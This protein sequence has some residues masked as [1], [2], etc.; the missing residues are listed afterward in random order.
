MIKKI[1]FDLDGT[2]WETKK[3]Y[4]YAYEKL[5]E[6]YQI[7]DPI[8][9]EEVLKYMGVKLD[10]LIESLF[11]FIEDKEE[12]AR[13]AVG[14][15][16]EY[17]YNN[18]KT[19]SDDMNNLFSRLSVNYDLFIISNCPR[20]YLEAFF[21]IANVKSFVK[22]CYTIEDDSKENNIR[23]ITNDYT[24]KAIFVG[25]AYTDYLAIEDHRKVFFCYAK[26]GY[27][28]ALEYDYS[29]E[30]LDD[31]ENVIFDIAKK[32]RMLKNDKYEIISS[33][34]SNLTLIQKE[35]GFYFGFL[36]LTHNENDQ[37]VINKLKNKIGNSE[38][39]GPIN[40]STWYNYRI[41]LDNLDLKLYPDCIND[42]VALELFY[43]NGFEVCH[44][45]T[46]T[47]AKINYKLW[48]RGKKINLSSDYQIK[49]IHGSEC[50]QYL[51][52][53]Y[54]VAS[55]A[56]MKADY[57]EPISLEDFKTLYID[58][59]KFCN[60]DLFLIYFKGE[61]IAFNFCYEDLE[62][63]FYVCKTTAIKSKHQSIKLILK[64][65]DLSYDVMQKYGYSKTLHHFQN[66]RT[67]V[68]YAIF[69]DN[70]LRQKYYGLL[71]YKNDK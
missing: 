42:S 3:S 68:S 23:R 35:K 47:I 9:P 33:R 2:L 36:N 5:C 59:I 49:V 27:K 39:I 24:E 58:N 1:I 28:D 32:D 19:C 69:K 61:I 20:S 25:D 52:D 13:L 70:I 67:Q 12:L 29:I 55:E 34:D 62:K 15:S 48:E 4:L 65:T 43:E 10:E 8:S 11:S 60:P 50:Y 71:R 18:P 45:Y 56:F 30:R 46:S 26:Y 6:Y 41:S 38:V 51:D 16:I 21:K 66:D 37:I 63:R 40:G 57:Y 7:K 14:Y 22:G 53:L 64:L 17:I 31:I 44:K 54:E